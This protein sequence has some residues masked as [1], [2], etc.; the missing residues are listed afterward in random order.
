MK[1]IIIYESKHGF[2]KKVVEYLANKLDIQFYMSGEI[3][4]IAIYDNV[5]IASPIY[6]GQI[7]KN[8]AQFI[9]GN[10]DELLKKN[11]YLVLTSMNKNEFGKMLEYNFTKELLEKAKIIQSGGAYYLDKMKWYEKLAVRIMGKVKTSSEEMNYSQLD[12]IVI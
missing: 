10:Q 1:S 8:I 6:I 11:V 9:S 4:D 3:E 7:D 12:S 2:T 5:I